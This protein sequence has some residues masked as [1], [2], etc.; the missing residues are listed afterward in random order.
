MECRKGLGAHTAI[1]AVYN[2][3]NSS[4][5]DVDEVLDLDLNEANDPNSFA[6]STLMPCFW[7]LDKG[8]VL[9]QCSPFTPILQCLQELG[10]L[11]K[12]ISVSSGPSQNSRWGVIGVAAQCNV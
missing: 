1:G 4:I 11:V 10:K 5:D 8:K 9:P 7:L 6:Y 3:T 12:V 2:E